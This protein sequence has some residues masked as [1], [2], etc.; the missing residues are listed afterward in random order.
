MEFE[1]VSDPL[2]EMDRFREQAE[3]AGI[4]L[5]EAMTLATV[6]AEGKPRARVVLLKGRRERELHFFTNYESDKG[7]ELDRHLEAAV[8][9]HYAA[10]EL[11][12]RVEGS[13]SR[14]SEAQSDEYFR[15]RPRESQL[16]AWA[17]DQSAPVASR[18]VL[19]QSLALVR[20]RFEGVEV[21]RPPHWGGYRL[22]AE[23]VELWLGRQGR[24]HDRARYV[25][26]QGAWRC[27]RLQP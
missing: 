3:R 4:P 18:E 6:D 26:N 7:R 8:C 1:A 2:L 23:K 14:L 9:I 24:L 12:V 15:T 11:Q 22:L 20:Q 10:L 25:F 21:P 17:S 16:G 5:P 13:V 19:E 27:T